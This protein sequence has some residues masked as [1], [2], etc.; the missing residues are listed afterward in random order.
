MGRPRTWP[1]SPEERSDR[2]TVVT[3]IER[4]GRDQLRFTVADL[5]KRLKVDDDVSLHHARD[6]WR[7]V[8]YLEGPGTL[9]VQVGSRF[10]TSGTSEPV[11]RSKHIFV[12]ASRLAEY[13]AGLA[14][15]ELDDIER[16]RLALWVAFRVCAVPVAT[17]AVT[18]VL[19][20]ILP[21][22]LEAGRQT[23][24]YLTTL[25][26]RAVPLAQKVRKRNERW[27]QWKPLGEVPTVP[28]FDEWV[29]EARRFLARSA[30]LAGA[31]HAT[32]NEVAREIV[33]IA[34]KAH[35]SS[36][37]PGGRSVTMH[38]I[39]ASID[40]NARARFLNEHLKRIGGPL[41][42][43][44][45][46]VTK[47]SIAG[48]GRVAQRVVKLSNPWTSATYYDVPGLPGFDARKLV[49]AMR[50]LPTKL[51]AGALHELSMERAAALALER[52]GDSASRAIASVRLL[53]LQHEMDLIGEPLRE[54]RAQA[55]LL[56]K[57]ERQRLDDM[58]AEY[59]RLREAG[60][61]TAEA[62]TSATR[63]LA[64]FSLTPEEVLAVDRPLLTGTEYASWFSPKTLGQRS[65]A[66]F[67]AHASG[68]RRY[69]N[70]A[71]LTRADPDPVRAAPTA[72][73]R[74]D[75]LVYAAQ[76]WHTPLA[77]FLASGGALL[78]P[79][80]RDPRVPALLLDSEDDGLR[81][82][83]LAALSLLGDE[84]AY[85]L[86]ARALADGS[87]GVR[88]SDAVYALLVLRRFGS[89][90]VPAGVRRSADLPLL[91]VLAAA[92]KA[93]LVGNWLLQR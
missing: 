87:S 41:S 86:S 47:K 13:K 50:G 10:E 66:Q 82:Q 42:A 45:G 74:V 92:E 56:S 28:E 38:D 54:T 51:S 55:D 61:T 71:F 77:G 1:K 37:W 69:P 89:S 91:R 25:S 44:L 76:R 63:A 27:V 30:I 14:R 35:R 8:A 17:T 26:K 5:R 80:L 20:N 32:K 70:P 12:L 7:Y 67:L 43:V 39:R 40:V 79:F 19:R 52:E 60:G 6:L 9:L 4:V 64:A 73:D 34:V 49:V 57:A 75:A 88:P 16:V 93:A 31:D 11:A 53:H 33:E 3:L 29:H 46:D 48:R 68:L 90:L 22:A 85:A 83:A 2:D 58:A 21:L 59:G 62:L 65:P 84:R 18:K 24:T 23:S 36:R 78:G 81:H 15:L 72:V